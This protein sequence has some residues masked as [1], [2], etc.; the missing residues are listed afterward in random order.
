MQDSCVD[1][2]RTVLSQIKSEIGNVSLRTEF[3][4]MLS[5]S[6]EALIL[7]DEPCMSQDI[8]SMRAR[9]WSCQRAIS[10]FKAMLERDLSTIE[11]GFEGKVICDMCVSWQRVS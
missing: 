3:E 11:D 2:L 4:P 9:L 8:E 5:K 7:A 1:T 10:K 6:V